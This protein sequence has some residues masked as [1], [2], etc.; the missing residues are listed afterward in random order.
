MRRELLL[1]E[2]HQR[3]RDVRQ[4]P[5]GYLYLLTEETDGALPF[6][7]ALRIQWAACPRAMQPTASS[8]AIR[9]NRPLGHDVVDS[10]LKAL[11]IHNEKLSLLGVGL[12]L[13]PRTK[14]HHTTRLRVLILA[15]CR[16]I[17]RIQNRI[18]KINVIKGVE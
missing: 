10:P 18:V 3:I 15:E 2:L 8:P 11:A 7:L 17:R 9:K 1:T 16:T 4:A 13:E 6:I 14:L 12:K 5:D